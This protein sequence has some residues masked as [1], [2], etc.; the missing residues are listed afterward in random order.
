MIKVSL[1]DL[2]GD[3][4]SVVDA[5]RVSFEKRSENYTA[6]QNESLIKFLARKGHEIPF[7]HTAITF[8]VGAP[9][10]VRTQCFKSKIGFVESEES[11]RYITSEPEI[12]IPDAFR[13]A[14]KDKKQGSG[15]FHPDSNFLLAEYTTDARYMVGK[16]M[17]AIERGVCPE[18][19]RFWL[20]QGVMVNWVWTGSLLAYARFYNLRIKPDAQKEVR[21]VAVKVDEVLSE[22]F[23]ISWNAL[24]RR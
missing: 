15:G 13:K 1:I 20:P 12:F 9:V 8:R 21:D 19:A 18:Q 2:M 3:D 10:P 7:A 22:L 16:Y 4:D 14:V 17:S 6:E 5:A 23:P 11:R 24:I